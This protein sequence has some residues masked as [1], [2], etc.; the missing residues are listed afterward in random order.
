LSLGPLL[1]ILALS[2]AFDETSKP[3]LLSTYSS[4]YILTQIGGGYLAN[5]YVFLFI[6]SSMVGILAVIMFYV[7]TM[8][9]TAEEWT[10]AFFVMGLVVGPL[11]PAGSRAIYCN[12]PREKRVALET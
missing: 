1:P 8:A 3:G 2:L 6:L 10:R 5:K 12:V 9:T 4:G 7:V 11:F